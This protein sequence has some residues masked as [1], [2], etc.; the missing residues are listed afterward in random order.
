M[1]ERIPKSFVIKIYDRFFDEAQRL[2]DEKPVCG[3]FE[4]GI[5]RARI[6]CNDSE[7]V[8]AWEKHTEKGGLGICCCERC[9]HLTRNGCT[10]KNLACKLFLCHYQEEKEPEFN[11]KLKK[12]EAEA[13]SLGFFNSDF[14]SHYFVSKNKII[15]ETLKDISNSQ[16]LTDEWL[17]LMADEGLMPI[18]V[19]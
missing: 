9:K 12:I 6:N 1:L 13:R 16:K 15:K 14:Y 18:S 10:T 11:E 3:N 8:Y 7:Q 4:F 17:E 19:V 5:C 2:F